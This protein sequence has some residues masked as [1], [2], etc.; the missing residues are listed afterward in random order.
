MAILAQ[1]ESDR[2]LHDEQLFKEHI[3]DGCTADF[4]PL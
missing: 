1:L 4:M 2:Q 3:L